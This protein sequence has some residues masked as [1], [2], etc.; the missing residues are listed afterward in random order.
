MLLAE[1]AR[2]GSFDRAFARAAGQPESAFV[3]DWNRSIS[4]RFVVLKAWRFAAAFGGAGMAILVIVAFVIRR[5]RLAQAARE[6][7]WEEFEESM[8]RQLRE[9]PHR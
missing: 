1:L 9:W 4:K 8:D 7:E 3:A 6:W 5:R 2:T